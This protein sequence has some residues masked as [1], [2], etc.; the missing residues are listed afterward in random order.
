MKAGTAQKLL[1]NTISTVTTV[2]LDVELDALR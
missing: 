2:R 1:L